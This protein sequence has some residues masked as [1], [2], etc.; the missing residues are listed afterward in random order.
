MLL[1]NRGDYIAVNVV[2]KVDEGEDRERD[3]CGARGTHRT[4]SYSIHVA[5]PLRGA[6]GRSDPLPGPGDGFAPSGL[7]ITPRAILS[8][9]AGRDALDAAVP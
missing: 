4:K 9:N 6:K 5:S 2:E 7:A 3:P 1:P 8:S